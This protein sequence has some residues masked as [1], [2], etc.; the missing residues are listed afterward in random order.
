MNGGGDIL[1]RPA[2]KGSHGFVQVSSRVGVDEMTVVGAVL[3]GLAAFAATRLEA[4]FLATFVDL[5]LF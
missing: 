1:A 5:M 2:R 3:R 4:A